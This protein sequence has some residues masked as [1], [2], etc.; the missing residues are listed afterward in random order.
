VLLAVVESKVALVLSGGGA[1]G[2][3]TVGALQAL[4]KTEYADT[5]DVVIGASIGA[6]NAGMMAQYPKD[7]QCSDAV[8]A[9]VKFWDAIETPEDVYTSSSRLHVGECLNAL[10]AVQMFSAWRTYGGMCDPA[11]GIKNYRRVVQEERVR[12]PAN[13]EFYV[14]A[15]SL[16]DTTDSRWFDRNSDNVID[17]IIASGAISPIIYPHKIGD[18]YFVDGSLFHNTPVIKALEIGADSVIS[19]LLSSLDELNEGAIDLE[20]QLGLGRQIMQY[21]LSVL[22]RQM[23]LQKELSFACAT[24]PGSRIVAVNPDSEFGSLLDFYADKIQSMKAAGVRAVE[25]GLVDVCSH[26][27]IHTVSYNLCSTKAATIYKS[28]TSSSGTNHAGLVF[29]LGLTCGLVVSA[30]VALTALIVTRLRKRPSA[31]LSASLLLQTDRDAC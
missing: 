28:N 7:K 21:Y 24:F 20:S 11:P 9:M 1:K 30:M 26:P 6:L 29:G 19:V 4:C 31:A 15:S 10:N 22:D 2:A 8:P 27:A 17:A 12:D 23:M 5:W 14:P 3:F 13:V 16:S 18:E 25:Q